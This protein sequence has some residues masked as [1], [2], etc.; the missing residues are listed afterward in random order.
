V[1]N[2]RER[3]GGAAADLLCKF[4]ER[5]ERKRCS[6]CW[7]APSRRIGGLGLLRWIA[8]R[9]GEEVLGRK[10]R[11]SWQ[12]KGKRTEQLVFSTVKKE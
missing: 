11:S 2:F 4:G 1:E 3:Q 9:F 12:W 5:R 6:A 10:E 7:L 8:A